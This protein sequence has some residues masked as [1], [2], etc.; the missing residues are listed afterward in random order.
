MNDQTANPSSYLGVIYPV[1]NGTNYYY[2]ANNIFITDDKGLVLEPWFGLEQEYFMFKKELILDKNNK[3]QDVSHPY[4]GEIIK[5]NTNIDSIDN[6]L[7]KYKQG[8]SIGFTMR[9]SL[10]AKGLIP[11]ANGTYKISNKYK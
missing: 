1:I 7:R 5:D 10:K 6:L 8:K 3:M 4:L 9:S 2:N 11:R